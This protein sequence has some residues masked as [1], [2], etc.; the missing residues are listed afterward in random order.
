MSLKPKRLIELRFGCVRRLQ[1]TWGFL[2][3]L[4]GNDAF[5][6]RSSVLEGSLAVG[7]AVRFVVEPAHPHA[8]ANCV[9]R[10][11]PNDAIAIMIQALD[12]RR[13]EPMKPLRLETWFPTK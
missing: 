5:V 10:L 3:Q 9:V 7:D 2:R 13:V 12:A 11:P 6:H 8:R 4:D 1:R